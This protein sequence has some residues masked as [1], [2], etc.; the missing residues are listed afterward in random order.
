MH[1]VNLAIDDLIMS[2]FATELENSKY[3][4]EQ[5]AFFYK[6]IANIM[7]DSQGLE[8]SVQLIAISNGLSDS[9]D[10][11]GMYLPESLEN[12]VANIFTANIPSNEQVSD[13]EIEELFNKYKMQ[14]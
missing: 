2:I 14:S 6:E 12:R 11:L 3:T 5:K 10:S 8:G 4:L 9:F 1:S 7:S 13:S